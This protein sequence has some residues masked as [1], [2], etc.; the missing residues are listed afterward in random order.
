MNVAGGAQARGPAHGIELPVRTRTAAIIGVVVLLDYLSK[1]YIRAMFAPFDV[2]PVIPRVFNIVHNENP[3]AAF[4]MLADYGPWRAFLLVGVSVIM[5]G[6]IGFLL[7]KPRAVGLHHTELVQ[8]AL[9]LVFAGALGNVW[10]RLFRGTVTDFLQVFIGSYE[11]P[12][13]NA[14]DSAITIGACRLIIDLWRN[15]RHHDAA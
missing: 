10:D 1:F 9:A 2:Y 12:S 11:F 3:G 6:V 8:V 4:G 5:M 15:R 7:W 14:A 13:F